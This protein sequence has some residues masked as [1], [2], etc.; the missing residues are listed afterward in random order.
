MS[1]ISN[2]ESVI[3]WGTMRTSL[4]LID[5]RI[6]SNHF[7]TGGEDRRRYQIYHSLKKDS[8][9]DAYNGN[10]QKTHWQI[11][12]DA[13]LVRRYFLA[14]RACSNPTIQL[15]SR[16]LKRNKKLTPSLN[17]THDALFPPAC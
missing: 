9:T 12:Q 11:S 15:A 2:V 1:A 17:N 14:C 10:H 4:P 7:V 3:M 6:G 16:A 5:V 13:Q 8:S